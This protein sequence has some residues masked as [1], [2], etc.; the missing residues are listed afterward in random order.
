MTDKEALLSIIDANFNICADVFENYEDRQKSIKEQGIYA[1]TFCEY[2]KCDKDSYYPCWQ[3][4]I[5]DWI[6]E[7]LP[8]FDIVKKK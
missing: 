6:L 3:H 2:N 7:A 1:C 5:A 4:M 8:Q